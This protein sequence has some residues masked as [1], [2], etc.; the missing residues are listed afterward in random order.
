MRYERWMTLARRQAGVLTRAQCTAAGLSGGQ[1]DRLIERGALL[2]VWPGVLRVRAVPMRQDT[3]LWQAVLATR[4]RL[5][6]ASA[7]YVWGLLDELPPTIEIA[8]GPDRRVT[9]PAGVK[10]RRVAVPATDCAIRDGLPVTTRTRSAI[11]FLAYGPMAE[12]VPFADRAFAQGWVSRAAIERRLNRPVTGNAALRRIL[13]QVA[14]GAAAESER[15]LHRLLR[16]AGISGWVA[17]HPVHFDGRLLARIDV[18][19]VRQLLAIEVDGFAYHS[20]RGRFQRD[21]QR[22]NT[23]VALGWTVLRFTWS[24]LHDRPGYVLGAIVRQLRIAESLPR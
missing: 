18:A 6:A 20:A 2:S 10:L 11:D 19:F 8:V 9:P 16:G 5:M 24:D 13:R 22:Q 1:I 15:R 4:G 23:L 21:R 17:N 7:L 3:T 14:D 12:T